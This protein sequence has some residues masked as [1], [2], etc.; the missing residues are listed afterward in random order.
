M[1]GPESPR[2]VTTALRNKAAMN[3]RTFTPAFLMALLAALLLTGCGS[4]GTSYYSSLKRTT[5]DTK[6]AITGNRPTTSELFEEENTPLIDISYDAADMMVGQFLP[7]LNKRS[8]VYYEPFTNRIDMGDPSPF[9]ALVSEQVAARLAQRAFMITQGRPPKTTPLAA[10]PAEGQQPPATQ[11]AAKPKTYG[12]NE[13]RPCMMTGT[14]LVTDKLIYLSARIATLDNGLVLGAHSWTVPVNRTIRELLPQI[15]RPTGGMKPA[16]RT[17][18]KGNAHEIA[19][20][21][22]QPQNYI[23]R[24]L[25]R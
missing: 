23:D 19:N 15:K 6:N 3:A 24:D 5:V 25:V 16:V 8:P 17:Q 2:P 9:G 7:E 13:P 11:A 20:P 22:G 10:A 14:Y 18:L 12:S 4:P 1:Q 21:S